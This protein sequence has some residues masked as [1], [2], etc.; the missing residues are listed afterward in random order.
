MATCG[1]RAVALILCLLLR[2][3]RSQVAVEEAHKVDG[4]INHSVTL[5][6]SITRSSNW[7]DDKLQVMWFKNFTEKLWDC[8]VEEKKTPD[9]RS[10][11]NAS[12]TRISWKSFGNADLE[13]R[14]LQESDAGRY[15]CWILLSD[16]YRR[17]DLLLRVHGVHNNPVPG[18]DSNGQRLGLAVTA[19]S[20]TIFLLSGWPVAI[21]LA[22]MIWTPRFCIRKRKY[23]L[24]VI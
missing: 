19:S 5:P 10:S 23:Q 17:R 13:I 15:Q 16:A 12:R 18:K 9:C 14:A 7:K 3:S 22:G 8:A 24:S 4:A 6:C 20:W 1:D 2:N 11:P 21:F